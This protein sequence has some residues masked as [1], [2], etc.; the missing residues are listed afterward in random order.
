MEQNSPEYPTGS[1]IEETL[2][3]HSMGEEAL[4]E[5]IRRRRAEA[6]AGPAQEMEARPN[7]YRS[8]I[9][10]YGGFHQADMTP[11]TEVEHS[12]SKRLAQLMQD[13]APPMGPRELAAVADISYEHSRKMVRGLAVP[14]KHIIRALAN[15]FSVDAAELQAVASAD[16]FQ[17]KFGKDA[18]GSIFNPEV[19]PFAENWGRLTEA[20]KLALLSHLEAFVAQNLPDTSAGE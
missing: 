2:N 11:T 15:Y 3:A 5:L 4:V 6:E 12:F 10:N 18:P 1:Q 8:G 14:T 16:K 7:E 20:Q 9:V 19:A 17:R 13:H